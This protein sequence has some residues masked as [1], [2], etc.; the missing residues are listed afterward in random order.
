M[1]AHRILTPIS[2]TALAGL[3]VGV[4]TLGGTI[5]GETAAPK[6]DRF[7][8]VG[9]SLCHGQEWPNI[10]SECLAWSEGAPIPGTIRFVTLST[11]DV[12]AGLT[13]LTREP[14]DTEHGELAAY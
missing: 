2:V 3:V 5:A 8:V 14:V 9:D 7:A 10:T 1:N 12:E 4:A 11:T 6:A 13:T